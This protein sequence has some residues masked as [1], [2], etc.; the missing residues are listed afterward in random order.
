[1]PS[2]PPLLPLGNEEEEH[3]PLEPPTTALLARNV[4]SSVIDAA[5]TVG[6]V[7]TLEKNAQDTVPL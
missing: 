5:H 1:M 7:S 2:P 4:K 3:P 6:R